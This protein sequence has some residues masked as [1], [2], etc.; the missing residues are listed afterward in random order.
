MSMGAMV[1]HVTVLHGITR[2][3]TLRG[4]LVEYEPTGCAVV[5]CTCGLD[6]GVVPEAQ[7]AQ[8]ADDHRRIAAEARV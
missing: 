6:S 2:S 4:G 7:A 1:E 5:Q 3:R 8:I